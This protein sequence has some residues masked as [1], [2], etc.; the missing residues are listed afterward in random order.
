MGQ[1]SNPT[2]RYPDGNQRPRA[3]QIKNLAEDVHAAISAD[4]AALGKITQ[5]TVTRRN[6][7]GGTGLATQNGVLEGRYARIGDFAWVNVTFTFGSNSDRGTTYY[8]FTLPGHIPASQPLV[9]GYGLAASKAGN[10]VP[11]VVETNASG[12]EAWLWMH[13]GNRVGRTGMPGGNWEVGGFIR[14]S[15]WWPVS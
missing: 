6:G 1:T 10:R 3:A 5:Y 14:F 8:T 4:R 12:T 15:A 9:T 7:A 11:V 2:L 13:D